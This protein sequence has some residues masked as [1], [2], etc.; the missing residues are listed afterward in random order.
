MK[1]ALRV[2]EIVFTMKSCFADRDGKEI[3]IFESS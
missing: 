1:S 3:A 2:R